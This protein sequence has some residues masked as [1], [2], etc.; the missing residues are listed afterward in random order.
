MDFY[1]APETG[2]GEKHNNANQTEPEKSRE[3]PGNKNPQQALKIREAR[4]NIRNMPLSASECLSSAPPAEAHSVMHR[5]LK[6]ENVLI[7]D[8]F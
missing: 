1:S 4:E 7:K 3:N 5:D 8:V 2:H 6:L